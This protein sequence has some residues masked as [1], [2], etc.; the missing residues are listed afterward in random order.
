MKQYQ[1]D[2]TD[3][4]DGSVVIDTKQ[5]QVYF[6]DKDVNSDDDEVE[7]EHRTAQLMAQ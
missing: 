2:T 4:S 5:Q 1:V 7:L 6:Q 3:S